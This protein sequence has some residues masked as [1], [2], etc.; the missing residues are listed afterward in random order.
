MGQWQPRKHDPCGSSLALYWAPSRDPHR[1][2]PDK[3]GIRHIPSDGRWFMFI[4]LDDHVLEAETCPA[5]RREVQRDL[6]AWAARLRQVETS[7][8]Q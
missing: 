4:E 2:A 8:A 3:S 5:R 6:Q 7:E 1:P